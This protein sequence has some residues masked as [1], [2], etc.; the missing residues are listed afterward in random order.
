VYSNMTDADKGEHEQ[1]DGAADGGDS[2]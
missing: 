2:T 1:R